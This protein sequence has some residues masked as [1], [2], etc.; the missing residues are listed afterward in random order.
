M[1]YLIFGALILV[2]GNAQNRSSTTRTQ[3]VQTCE[4]TTNQPG[5]NP[6][7]T[8]PTTKSQSPFANRRNDYLLAGTYGVYAQAWQRGDYPAGWAKV[9]YGAM[10]GTYT[11]QTPTGKGV[12]TY[13]YTV[14]GNPVFELSGRKVR[15]NRLP[16]PGS[17]LVVYDVWWLSSKNERTGTPETWKL[18]Q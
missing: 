3:S 11:V 13:C 18:G 6:G 1:R 17:N 7:R 16:A 9:A 14:E 10:P 15:F 2:C 8:T 5:G 12:M 4:A